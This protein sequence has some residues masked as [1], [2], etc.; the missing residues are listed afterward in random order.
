[1]ITE[2]NLKGALTEAALAPNIADTDENVVL[3][4]IYMKLSLPSLGRQLFGFTHIHGP[5]G[6]VFAIK[7]KDTGD[8]I[9][10]L[11]NDI[12]VEDDVSNGVFI[13]QEAFDDMANMF[14]EDVKERI[15]TYMKRY[16]NIDENKY[17]IEFLKNHSK[18]VPA[19]TLT[20]P[21]D[22]ETTWKEIAYKATQLVLEANMSGRITFN[23]YMLLPYKYASAIMTM[24]PMMI[25][26]NEPI[27]DDMYVG[28]ICGMSIYINPDIEDDNIYV[29]LRDEV[30]IG[31]CSAIFT[32]YYDKIIGPVIDVKTGNNKYF[33]FK[34]F[35]ITPNPLHTETTPMM[36]KFTING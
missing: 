5:T 11:R 33:I 34:R 22:P 4:Q 29:G 15:L 30:E 21:L 36:F 28:N 6:G 12:E 13:S 7:S 9:E 20:N 14:G 32:S 19:L 10:L 3:N 18:Q 1:M 31:K 35:A 26:Q 23:S 8:G 2:D 17:C 24:Y 25:R 16:A 27:M